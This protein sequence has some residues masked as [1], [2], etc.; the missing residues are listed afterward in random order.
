MAGMWITRLGINTEDYNSP[1]G[2]SQV[3]LRKDIWSALP[4][5]ILERVLAR[6]PLQS[7]LRLQCVCKKW[8]IKL[9]T[10]SFIRLCEAEA[11]NE[12]RSWF[13]TFSHTAGTV[14]LAYDSRLAKWHILALGFLPFDLDSKSPLAAADGLICLGAGWRSLNKGYTPSRLVVCNPVSKFWRDV[15]LPSEMDPATSLISAA[16]IVVDRFAGT[17]KLIMVAEVSKYEAAGNREQKL[18]IAFVFDSITQGWTSYQTLINVVDPFT[19]FLA[20]HFRA[21]VGFA[22]RSVLCSVVCEG[23]FYCLTSRPYQLHAFN[24]E[25]EEWTRVRITLPTEVRGPSLAGRPGHLFL[26]G[27]FQVPLTLHSHVPLR[28]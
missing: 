13:L 21:L 5:D 23:V 24:V 9:R 8:K 17:Y 26:V 28:T 27:E 25:T 1:K 11:E 20:S 14:G 16:G 7:L 6:L 22:I 18:L 2:D 3:T 10:P 19:T 4:E 15:P 12:R